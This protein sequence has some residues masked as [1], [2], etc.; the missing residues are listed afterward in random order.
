M[1]PMTERS[2]EKE[3]LRGMIRLRTKLAIF[4]HIY[5]YS[6]RTVLL[7]TPLERKTVGYDDRQMLKSPPD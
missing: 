7:N 4:K 6:I 2:Q 1:G 3:R 5:I